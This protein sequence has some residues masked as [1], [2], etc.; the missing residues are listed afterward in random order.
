[1]SDTAHHTSP[2]Q[3]MMGFGQVRHTRLRPKHHAF[4]YDTFFL[5]L[6]MR[7]LHTTHDAILPINRAG[8]ISFHEADHGDGRNTSQGGRWRG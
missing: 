1:M 4:N 5:M 7:N 6:P 2:P 8:A 3:A